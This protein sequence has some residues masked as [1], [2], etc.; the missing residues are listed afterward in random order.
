MKRL[1]WNHWNGLLYWAGNTDH[2]TAQFI[3]KYPYA[4][5]FTHSLGNSK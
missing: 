2:V 1:H 5:D 3:S 4:L